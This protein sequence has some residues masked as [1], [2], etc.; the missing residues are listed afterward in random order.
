MSR[1]L[2]FAAAMLAAPC[3]LAH[4]SSTPAAEQ[5]PGYGLVQSITP[6][7]AEPAGESASTGSSAPGGPRGKTTYLVRVML[8]DGSI[9]IRQLN[10]RSVARGI[11]V[12]RRVLITNAGD[13]L[14]E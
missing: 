7:R 11:G 13:V 4:G 12:G 5:H 9:Q 2:L 3:A 1:A 10:K 14:P 6:V 8:D